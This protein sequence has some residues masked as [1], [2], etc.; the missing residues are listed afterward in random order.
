M[1]E[2]P[3][4]PV[5]TDALLSDAGDLPNELFGAYCRLLFRWWREGAKPE[6]DERRLARW[7]GLKTADLDDLKEFLTLTDEG[8]IQKRLVETFAKAKAKS[9]KAKDAAARRWACERNADASKNA[10][11]RNANHNHNHSSKI[12]LTDSA[13]KRARLEGFDEFWKSYPRRQLESGSLTR[14]SRKKAE[15]QWQK[16]KPDDQADAV[17]GLGGYTAANPDRSKYVQDVERYLR[18]RRWLDFEAGELAGGS[19]QIEPRPP[20]DEKA[21]AVFDFLHARWG[22]QV[23]ASW[24]SGPDGASILEMNCTAVTIAPLSKIAYERIADKYWPS[25]LAQFGES[26]RLEDLKSVKS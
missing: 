9:Q 3:F 11:E 25:L 4:M 14:G 24:F 16:L 22:P 10:C 20:P 5:A 7:A 21:R 15:A 26:V 12:N 6:K 13:P 8:W 18:D 23:L 1:A 2:L 19:Q 17:A